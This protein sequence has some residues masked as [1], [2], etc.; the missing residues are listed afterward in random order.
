MNEKVNN[1]Q[2]IV[3]GK[4]PE[5]SLALLVKEYSGKIT[6]STS[7]GLEDQAITHIIFSNNLPIEI[8]TLETGRLFPE[9]YAVWNATR[10]R[11]G[12]NIGAFYPN[13]QAVQKMVSEKGP[14]SFYTSIENRLE[15]CFRSEERRVGKEGRS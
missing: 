4:S 3:S 2:K 12:K 7:F 8:F 9:T 11:Y 5:E 10:E 1:I 13:E 15:G 6:F 14:N